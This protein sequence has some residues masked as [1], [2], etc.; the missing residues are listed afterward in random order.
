VLSDFVSLLARDRWFGIAIVAMTLNV[1]TSV[2]MAV[3]VYGNYLSFLIYWIEI[4]VFALLLGAWVGGLAVA[5]SA[6]SLLFF[7][8]PPAF[9]FRLA[10]DA[11]AQRFGAFVGGAV[12]A[13]TG[14]LLIR[15]WRRR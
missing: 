1:T 6:A 12:I 2:N 15:A 5:F 13:W 8:I 11:D 7:I 10:S 9:S 4:A 3:V 14:G